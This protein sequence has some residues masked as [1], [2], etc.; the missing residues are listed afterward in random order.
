MV[1]FFPD[2]IRQG[3][4]GS[5]DFVF[6][7][8]REKKQYFGLL[9]A[10]PGNDS[11]LLAITDDGQVYSYIIR[12]QDSISKLNYFVPKS[13]SIGNEKPNS[14]PINIERPKP[15]HK[16]Y[17]YYEKFSKYLLGLDFLTDRSKRKDGIVL[18]LLETRYHID[19]VYMVFEI[20]NKSEI[21]FE[22]DYLKV[23]RVSTNKKRKASYQQLEL[24]IN[25]KCDFPEKVANGNSK[26]FVYV[27][28]KFS[29]GENEFIGLS[30]VEQNGNRKIKF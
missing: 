22:I 5:E 26:R 23:F 29:L 14:K 1:L 10:R 11:N 19:E 21:D 25:Y 8:N 17:D 2:Y 16:D 4:T 7:Y 3:I 30:L 28:P 18:K 20:K 24:D 27:L 6:T 9:Q 15:K 13:E 12:Y